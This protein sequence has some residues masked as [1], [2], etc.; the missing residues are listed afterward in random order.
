MKDP[1]ILRLA[2]VGL[3]PEALDL[4]PKMLAEPGFHVVRVLS[5]DPEDLSLRLSR[6]FGL[7]IGT[8]VGSLTGDLPE[9][10][11]VGPKVPEAWKS[12]LDRGAWRLMPEKEILE[13][14]GW[15][16]LSL[17]QEGIP[18]LGT[19]I[20]QSI[21][22]TSTPAA[23]PPLVSKMAPEAIPTREGLEPALKT[24]HGIECDTGIP[25]PLPDWL[26]KV[27]D[28][29]LLAGEIARDLASRSRVSALALRWRLGP[30]TILEASWMPHGW[31][32]DQGHLWKTEAC[33]GSGRLRQKADGL[34]I[35]VSWIGDGVEKAWNEIYPL[36]KNVGTIASWKYFW[37]RA[38]LLVQSA[39]PYHPDERPDELPAS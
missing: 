5:P 15:D 13:A 10:V 31:D 25:R 17:M 7:E 6:L 22:E 34:I 14:G 36:L 3:R 30:D 1:Q 35:E 8:E 19:E 39:E 27:M 26:H 21:L 9:V 38:R 32:D 24:E 37:D 12:F 11:V 28:P 2:M 4:L 20:T 29:E 16:E 33:A 23:N 18:A